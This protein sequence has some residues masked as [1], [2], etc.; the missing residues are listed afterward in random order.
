MKKKIIIIVSAFLVIGI[1]CFGDYM[2]NV[3]SYKNKVKS[4]EVSDVDLSK[5]KDGEYIG[6]YNV[7]FIYAKVAVTVKSGKIEKID[8][9]EHKNERGAPAEVIVDTMVSEQKID[10]DTVT[11][12]TNSSKVIKKAVENA[13]TK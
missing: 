9:L 7:D 11:G 13:L 4:I 10:V 5:I 12:A 8:I 2:Y 1:V 6:D 3:T